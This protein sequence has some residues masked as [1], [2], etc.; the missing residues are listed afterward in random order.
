PIAAARAGA[1]GLL[2]VEHARD[3]SAVRA[4]AQRLAELA[5]GRYGCL[6]GRCP[7]IAAAALAALPGADLVLFSTRPEAELRAGMNSARKDGRRL[8]AVVTDVAE[9]RLAVQCG[10]DLLVAKGEEAGG[11]IGSIKTLELAQRLRAEL[12]LPI[13]SWGGIDL[14]TAG[15]HG[16]A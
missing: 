1:I 15:A 5:R 9:A 4:Q 12:D 7:E 11:T 8:G 14:T 3:V 2:N 6:L 10:A 16:S 13:Y